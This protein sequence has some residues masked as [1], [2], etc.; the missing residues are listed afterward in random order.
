MLTDV[1]DPV[2]KLKITKALLSNVITNTEVIQILE[3]E[4]SRRE[5]LAQE[6]NEEITSSETGDEST[7]INNSDEMDFD[8]P[9]IDTSVD[10]I[11]PS[12]E[13]NAELDTGAEPTEDSSS[14]EQVLPT[15][16]DLGVDLT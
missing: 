4:I 13:T 1:E 6:E 5:K 10:S 16:A 9:S 2:N 8:M 3:D 15:P 12:E 14:S 11:I 7:D